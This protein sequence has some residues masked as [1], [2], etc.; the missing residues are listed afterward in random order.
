MLSQAS[1]TFAFDVCDTNGFER[2]EIGWVRSVSINK[3]FFIDF[4][5][6]KDELE[7]DGLPTTPDLQATLAKDLASNAYYRLYK[8]VNPPTYSDAVLTYSNTETFVGNC[9]LKK[10]YVFRTPLNTFHWSKVDSNSDADMLPAVRD[11]LKRKHLI[12]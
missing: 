5:V 10:T 4:K 9:W 2:S 7:E 11:L 12:N 3:I 6:N 8:S 1:T